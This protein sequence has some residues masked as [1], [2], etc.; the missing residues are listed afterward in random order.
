[1]E[2]KIIQVPVEIGTIQTM[3][4]GGNK[5][6][7]YTPSL[8]PAESTILFEFAKIKTA[9]MVLAQANIESV[10]VPETIPEFKG[11]KS[12]AQRVRNALYLLWQAKGKPTPTSEQFYASYME[13]ILDQIKVQLPQR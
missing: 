9:F 6:A 12:Y 5:I 3:A 2:P 8:N 4:D 13:K 7:L 11:E 10:E 1:M